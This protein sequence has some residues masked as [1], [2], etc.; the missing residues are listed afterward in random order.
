MAAY[1]DVYYFVV[2]MKTSPPYVQAFRYNGNQFLKTGI[3]A[4]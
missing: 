1:P 4:T 3:I 2:S